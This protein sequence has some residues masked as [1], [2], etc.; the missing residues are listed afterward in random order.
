[1]YGRFDDAEDSLRSVSWSDVP[2][3]I[4]A[5]ES[6][7][8]AAIAYA[9]GAYEDGLGYAVTATQQG[10]IETRAPGV[11]MSELAFRTYRNL[12]LALAGR[13]TSTTADELRT[14]MTRLPVLGQILAAWGLAMIAKS[15]GAGDELRAMQEFIERHAPHLAPVRASIS[16]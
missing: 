8:R 2:P 16:G 13:A 11:A 6:A 10:M 5:Q 3:F 1:L 9:R 14:A 7:A 4:Q 12:G 15:S